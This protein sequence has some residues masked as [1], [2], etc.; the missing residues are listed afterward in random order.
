MTARKLE[1]SLPVPSLS[2]TI[3]ELGQVRIAGAADPGNEGRRNA[4]CTCSACGQAGHARSNRKCP[5]RSR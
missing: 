3:D 1:G 2:V 5:A 4:P